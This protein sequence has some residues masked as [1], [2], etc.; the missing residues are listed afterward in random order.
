MGLNN[1]LKDRVTDQIAKSDIFSKKS[2]LTE[3]IHKLKD[4]IREENIS[5]WKLQKTCHRHSYGK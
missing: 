3:D 1:Q 4:T 2:Q 5:K